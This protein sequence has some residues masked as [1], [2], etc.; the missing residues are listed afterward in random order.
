MLMVA[1]RGVGAVPDVRHARR[2]CRETLLVPP[3]R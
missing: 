1:L 2:F 3:D